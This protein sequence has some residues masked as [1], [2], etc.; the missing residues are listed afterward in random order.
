MS[1]INRLYQWIIAK[2]L[3]L[4]THHD[5]TDAVRQ[6]HAPPAQPD[7]IQARKKQ[8]RYTYTDGPMFYLGQ[9]IV[10]K[11]QDAGHPAKIVECFRSF[12]R[13][14]E[15]YERRPRVTNAPP[16]ESAH[17]YYEAV[18]IVHETKGWDVGQEFW[19]ALA[20]AVRTVAEEHGVVL[21]HGH[22]WKFVDSAHIE[23]AD[24]KR[25]RNRYREREDGG[26]LSPYRPPTESELRRRF[27]EVLPKVWVQH[28]K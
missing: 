21:V 8:T 14:E 15:L 7:R 28:Q 23:M 10:R 22:Y 19:E 17:Q 20:S 3:P 13:Q 27:V 25:V 24:W 5:L 9:Q 2:G 16:G 26:A 18:D 1:F 11:M 6:M 4:E 12:E